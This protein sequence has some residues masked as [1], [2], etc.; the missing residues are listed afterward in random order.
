MR[1]YVTIDGRTFEVELAPDHVSVDGTVVRAELAQQPESEIHHL[2]VDGR[3]YPLVA[4]RG[5]G[6]GNWVLVVDGHRLEADVV[7]ERGRA[8]RRITGASA[9]PAGPKPVRA[10]MP[11]L[12]VRVDV[13]V[14]Q[15]VKQGQ[16]VVIMEAMKMENELKAE[17]PG[18][19][20][21]VLVKP[22]QAV[23]KG[24]VLVEFEAIAEAG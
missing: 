15:T 11:G 8:I 1:Y 7:D 6:R 5:N 23:E 18:I 19:V 12:I 3:S 9:A 17:A 24:A 22:G 14:G 13:E 10:P 16:G 21:K 2:L 4:S 20:S